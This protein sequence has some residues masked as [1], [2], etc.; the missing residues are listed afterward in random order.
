MS[1]L[2]MISLIYKH[3]P[4]PKTLSQTT[5]MSPSDSLK[6]V[7]NI[8]QQ[9]KPYTK[10]GA[11]YKLISHIERDPLTSNCN[12]PN[13]TLKV[14]LQSNHI[15][16]Q[17]STPKSVPKTHKQIQDF[18]STIEYHCASDPHP[19]LILNCIIVTS[20]DIKDSVRCL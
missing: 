12:L 11:T 7:C 8:H 19:P 4:N 1:S 2:P 18:R 5:H 20:Y 10:Q 14:T 15:A 16:T 6:P 3:C 13:Y 17:L 9:P